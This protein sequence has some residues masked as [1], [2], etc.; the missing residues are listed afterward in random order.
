MDAGPYSIHVEKRPLRLAFLLDK[1]RLQWEH[2]PAIFAYNRGK[3]GGRFNPLIGFDTDDLPSPAW[4]ILETLDPDIILSLDRLADSLLTDIDDRLSPCTVEHLCKRQEDIAPFRVNI[5]EEG[6]SILP[7][8]PNV[9][10]AAHAPNP[11]FVLLEPARE[12]DQDTRRFVELTFGHYDHFVALD[13]ALSQHSHKSFPVLNR[14]DLAT[15]LQQ[16]TTFGTFV[17]PT[18]ISTLP[19]PIPDAEYQRFGETFTVVVGDSL[20]D[21]IYFWNRPLY[22]PLWKRSQFNEVILP[23][24]LIKDE[25]FRPVLAEWLHRAAD[26]YGSTTT[27]VEFVSVSLNQSDLTALVAPLLPT[28]RAERI[29]QVVPYEALKLRRWPVPV[30]RSTTDSYRATASRE[31]IVLAEPDVEMSY[32]RDEH[33]VADLFVE[34]HSTRYRNY[35][36]DFWWQLPT[37]NGLAQRMFRRTSRVQRSGYPSALM[38]RGEPRLDIDL[39]DEAAI[40]ATLLIEQKPSG[41]NLDDREQ[42]AARRRF[43]DLR[44]S[45]KGRYLNGLL[46]LFGGLFAASN[47]LEVRYWRRM[48]TILSGIDANSDARRLETIQGRLRKRARMPLT[49][50]DYE[51]FILATG[52]YVLQVAKEVGREGREIPYSAFRG[53]AEKELSEYNSRRVGED[54]RP[55]DE[56]DLRRAMGELTE[57]RILL[58]GV[59]PRCPSC[60]SAYWYH[61]DEASQIVECK[62][63]ERR[64]ALNPQEDWFYRLNTLVQTA[65]YQGVIPVVVTLGERLQRSRSGFFY[66]TS[67]E[68]FLDEQG[69]PS[70][71][72][73]ALCVVDGKFMIGEVKQSN[74]LFSPADFDKLAEVAE[75]VQP[76]TVFVAS[77]DL[78]QQT[79]TITHGLARLRERLASRRIEVKWIQLSPHVFEPSP[80]R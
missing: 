54:S 53:E 15:A 41:S 27:R 3:W 70:H 77:L 55:F 10:V 28:V 21:A 66:R 78:T 43:H 18:Q 37:H 11:I 63:C 46:D 34:F 58:M 67:V 60:G 19:N 31:Q 4:D 5:F 71:E 44:T 1:R 62:G 48:F 61:I 38:K 29:A 17:H 73:D 16:L 20:D 32:S 75:R 49:A 36:R 40:F 8:W 47:V 24:G 59:R 9:R 69:P 52:E 72:I 7:T 14:P 22:R 30:I 65:F 57:A 25:A 76:D 80:I 13:R 50:G 64:H 56:E 42:L 79:T 35:I 23:T 39:L 33:W 68:L 26:P 45:D 12:L 74:G 6:L 51:R 2:L